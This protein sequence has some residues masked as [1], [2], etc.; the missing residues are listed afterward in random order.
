MC[1]VNCLCAERPSE[2]GT[3]LDGGMELCGCSGWVWGLWNSLNTEGILTLPM[4]LLILS[5]L[6][7]IQMWNTSFAQWCRVL[8]S[9]SIIVKSL[10]SFFG[11]FAE[12]WWFYDGTNGLISMVWKSFLEGPIGFT[13]VFSCAVV[14]WASP[15]RLSV[16]EHLEFHI[17]DARVKTCVERPSED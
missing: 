5:D 6:S 8:L 13:Y 4:L 14:G 2:E 7:L 9:I 3:P 17:L 15:V 16:S 11:C 1:S 12:M 10:I